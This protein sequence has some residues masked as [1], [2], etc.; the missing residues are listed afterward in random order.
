MALPD[1]LQNAVRTLNGALDLLDAAVER[2]QLAEVAR[3]D[4]AQETALMQEDRAHLGEELELS[5]Q[6]CE[7]LEAVGTIVEERLARMDDLCAS[8]RQR[9][10]D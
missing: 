8:L 4:R 9:T 3:A 6:A 10:A 1:T 2:R 7:R 5:E